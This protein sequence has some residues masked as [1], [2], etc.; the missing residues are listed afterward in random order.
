MRI[1]RRTDDARARSLGMSLVHLTPRFSRG[2]HDGTG[3]C[4]LQTVDRWRDAPGRPTTNG[5]WLSERQC[6]V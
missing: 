5:S 3:W 1:R 4:R 6:A 2:G